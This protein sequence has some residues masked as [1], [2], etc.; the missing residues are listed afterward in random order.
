MNHPL[1][2]DLHFPGIIIPN[3]AMVNPDHFTINVTSND[4]ASC[5]LMFTFD[6]NRALFEKLLSQLPSEA[7]SAISASLSA[8]QLQFREQVFRQNQF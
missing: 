6:F 8:H 3:L 1:D 4:L 5:P 7:A 2:A